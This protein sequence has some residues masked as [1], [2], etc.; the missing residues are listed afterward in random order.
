MPSDLTRPIRDPHHYKAVVMQQGRV[1]LDRD[2]NAL[3]DLVDGRIAADAL[4]EIGPCGTPDDGLAISLPSAEQP[5]ASYSASASHWTPQPW[6]FLVKPG[7][8]YV[9][10]QRVVFERPPE[11]LPPLS[12]FHQPD[13]ANPP[14]PFAH[15]TSHS[16]P[17]HEF[18][19][20]HAYEQEVG[21]VEDPDLLDVALGG[22]D[23]SQRVRLM[24]RIVRL[25]VAG[26][27]CA[28]ALADANTDWGRWGYRFDSA[29]MRLLPEV[30][31]QVG[32]TS[33]LTTSNPC[34]PVAEGGYLGA[35]NQLI[36]VMI[37]DP[38]SVGGSASL[39]WGYDNAS[40]LYRVT[41][42]TTGTVLQ[43]SQPPVDV[44]HNPSPNQIVEVLR[45]AA[46]LGTEPDQTDPTGQRT[47]VRCIAEAT[48]FVA[49]VVSY[50]SSD[51]SLVLEPALPTTFTSDP[52]PLF[53]RV[54][55]GRQSFDLS[56]TAPIVLTDPTPLA[57]SPGLQVTITQPTT[58]AKG[59]ALSAGAF[60]L[61]A[62]R[63]STPQAL[64]PERFLNGPQPPD[65]PRQW[66]CPLAVIDWAQR[67]FASVSTLASWLPSGVVHDCRV[68]FDNLVTLTNRRLGGCCTVT[69]W[70][71]DA[72]RLQAILDRASGDGRRVTVCL[73][74]GAYPLSQPLRLT[75]RH[76]HLIL[77]CCSGGATLQ[78]AA[79]A[80]LTAFTDGLVVLVGADGV[81][82]RGLTFLPSAVPFP[83][84]STAVW[85]EVGWYDATVNEDPTDFPMTA[86]IGLR[87]VN[88]R[89]LTVQNCRFDT[90]ST[91]LQPFQ[92]SFSA[93]LLASGDCAGLT[94]RGCRFSSGIA[95]T[96]T[97]VPQQEDDLTTAVIKD[98]IIIL[99]PR[100]AALFGVLVLPAVI[101]DTSVD[102]TAREGEFGQWQPV[103]LDRATIQENEFLSLTLAVAIWSSFGTL[104][105]R[106]NRVRHCLAG[107]WFF[108]TDSVD[109]YGWE[110]ISGSVWEINLGLVMGMAYPQP[111]GTDTSSLLRL[112]APQ[113]QVVK[114]SVVAAPP[115]S[116]SVPP[117]AR[118]NRQQNRLTALVKPR[119]TASLMSSQAGPKPSMISVVNNF[120]DTLPADASFSGDTA[121]WFVL[122][123]AEE[124]SEAEE[125][126]V[127][128]DMDT[129]L[130]VASNTIYG[131][132]GFDNLVTVDINNPTAM[133]GNVII[134]ALATSDT[135]ATPP[136]GLWFYMP[137]EEVK[138]GVPLLAISGNV[139]RGE[140]N[141]AQIR[142]YHV[143]TVSLE[144]WDLWN[145][146]YTAG[147]NVV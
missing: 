106:D 128:L 96:S 74:P 94:I 113:K 8:M 53:L 70:P 90:P 29:T 131:R 82:F 1:I 60:W 110:Y 13:W 98:P 61:F 19:Y 14:D 37:S 105:V 135:Q 56:S 79:N 52:N 100:Y 63:P 43:L 117:S 86:L 32:F 5:A 129:S 103:V 92:I 6:D 57:L 97:A 65:G 66:V 31:L 69:V 142:R 25:S 11:S 123:G 67:D 4:D 24:R 139:Q 22:P 50:T 108:G 114:A 109:L 132:P 26:T 75:R 2:F 23:T 18:I 77:E 127:A 93:G 34:D 7:I 55:V 95:L 145:A 81:T 89:D 62:V 87:S 124:D 138:E 118:T 71:S 42:D 46:V 73:M 72:P 45:T 68:C 78:T 47:I 35:E 80:D 121:L 122:G 51:N 41:V 15:S 83:T 116:A 140:S 102:T 76:S 27:D 12:Y 10:G 21:A 36:R 107:F 104:Q 84:V 120:L 137:N 99:Q 17:Q 115:A 49:T 111:A 28:T 59:A 40:F 44:F 101:P 147:A 33:A 64:Y 39:L 85:E 126:R 88:A 3:Q 91:S 125:G 130:L 141:I 144:T 38:G 20:L 9:G 16:F 112:L 48:G 133:V 30:R 134:H 136:Y 58:A 119:L 54:W 146:L 143:G